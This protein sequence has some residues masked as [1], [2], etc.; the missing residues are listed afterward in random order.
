MYVYA[1]KCIYMCWC[2]CMCVYVY[3]CKCTYTCRCIC[4]CMYVCGCVYVSMHVRCIYA[5]I[6]MCMYM[7]THVCVYLCARVYV[8][9]YACCMPA[10]VH[11]CVN[12]YMCICI[13]VAHMHLYARVCIYHAC[14]YMCVYLHACWVCVCVC[15]HVCV[16]DCS[17]PTC[18]K[19][20]FSCGLLG[21]W[22]LRQALSLNVKCTSGK[23]SFKN[24]AYWKWKCQGSVLFINCKFQFGLINTGVAYK[25]ML[26]ITPLNR[27]TIS[28]AAQSI[29][30]GRA[31]LFW[32]RDPGSLLRPHLYFLLASF[33]SEFPFQSLEV[34]GNVMNQ[35]REALASN[36][37]PRNHSP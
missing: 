22:A 19:H 20:T 30:Q 15:M 32:L 23:N 3:A 35:R 21:L 6:C 4:V 13:F 24:L 2:I 33:H 9:L 28:W 29:V 1:C 36:P 16:C 17:S 12:L 11:T 26:G 14:V 31:W 34:R 8:Y 5:F 25:S 27:G 37:S 10:C 18:F 7:S